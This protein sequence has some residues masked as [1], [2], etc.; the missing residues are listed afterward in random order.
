M[1]IRLLHLEET[2][3]DPHAWRQCDTAN[4]VWDFYKNG[5]DFNQPAVCWMG[6]YK[7]LILEFP[8]PEAAI[9]LLYKVF[10]PYHLVGRIFFLASFL[11]SAFYFRKVM[12][13][14]FTSQVSKMATL[15]YMMLPLSIY[16][17]RALHIDF[18]A[19][20]FSMAM[21]YHLYVGITLRS[22]LHLWLGC[23]FTTVALL[24]KA[25]Y[26]LVFGILIFPIALRKYNFKY[27]LKHFYLFAIPLIAFVLW[28][29]FSNTTNAM[30]PDWEFIPG[31]RKFDQNSHWYY[32]SLHQRMVGNN[33]VIILR[34]IYEECIGGPV[35]LV[36]FIPGVIAIARSEYWKPILIS[37]I[38]LMIYVAVFFNLNLQH[39]YYQIPFL[40]LAAIVLTF[41]AYSIANLFKTQANKVAIALLLTHAYFNFGYSER[42]YFIFPVDQVE[43]A[44]HI[45][46]HTE[47]NELVLVS[48]GGLS[49]HCPIILYRAH[50]NGW[51]IPNAFFD[52]K[53]AYKL[54]QEE[55]CRYLA[56][57]SGSELTGPLKGY[58]DFFLGENIAISNGQTLYLRDLNT[59]ANGQ[60][61]IPSDY[62]NKK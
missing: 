9:A 18:F 15:I 52:Q 11:F 61:Y 43:I 53:I 46:A 55:K 22:N 49:V 24:V 32:G 26:I 19:L 20:G 5:I 35:G 51:S 27:C 47:E 58:I 39:N 8:L 42:N 50:R 62:Q 28:T 14:K 2:I 30:A 38:G 10:G 37:L 25:P 33:W 60:P 16:Y 40:C 29:R 59:K 6:G 31:Y 1:G 3:D 34:R 13:L 54:N 36:L 17:S 21:L 4:Y 12:E 45:G 7:T 41:G 56:Y 48:Y 44:F 23:I 57:I